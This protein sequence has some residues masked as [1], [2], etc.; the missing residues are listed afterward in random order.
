MTDEVIDSPAS[1]V[2]RQAGNR[3]HTQKGILAWL[4]GRPALADLQEPARIVLCRVH[5]VPKPELG[6]QGKLKLGG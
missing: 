2:V 6:N 1:V 4:L 3:M 5:F